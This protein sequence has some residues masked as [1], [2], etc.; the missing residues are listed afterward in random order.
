MTTASVVVTSYRRP[1]ALRDC[2]AGVRAQRRAPDELI[3]VLHAEDDL[4]PPTLDGD[5]LRVVTVAERGS[6]AALNA[7]FAAATGA[8][9]ALIDDDAVPEPDWLE[10]ILA[11]FARDPRIAGV[12]GRDIVHDGG[13]I[14]GRAEQGVLGRFRGA[15]T[16]GRIQWFGR[17]VGNHH[18]GEGAARDVDV[19]KGANMAF[20]RQAVL[21]HGFDER[22]RGRGAQPHSEL[23]IC[24]PL[25][26]RG[27]RLIY[28]PAIL[29]NHYPAPRPAG[30]GRCDFDRKA[31]FDWT[32]N[33]AL[34]ILDHLTSGRRAAFALWGVLVGTKR[35]PG[36]AAVVRHALAGHPDAWASF[37]A[38]Q[39]ARFAAWRTHRSH[40]RLP[41]GPLTMTVVVTTYRRTRTL[42][43]C[44]DGIAAQSRP[45]D[46][47]LVVV[48]DS[49]EESAAF[50]DA[51]SDAR[52]V[53][54]TPTGLVAALNRGLGAATGDIV[55]FVDDD[56]VPNRD[57]LERL[58][59][60]FA[61][62]A[63][64]S[65]VGGRDEVHYGGQVRGRSDEGITVRTFGPPHV[66]RV[67]WFGRQLG[68]HHIG[69]G[70]ARDVDVLKGVNMSFRRLEVAELGFDE[71]LK[72]RGVEVHSELSICL[73]LRRRGLR[74]I[75]DPAILVR[76][77]PQSRGFGDEREDLSREAIHDAAHN[78]ALQLL[79]YLPAAQR[80]V[81]AVWSFAVGTSDAPGLA[82]LARHLITGV[83]QPW[84]R[85]TAT[86]AGRIAARKSRKT[87]RQS[88]TTQN[89]NQPVAALL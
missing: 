1:D 23:S 82:I 53:L 15:P 33:E 44:L 47:V 66:G 24:L 58:E 86:Q 62:D 56:A 68:N 60:H 37:G 52:R 10:R 59:A 17:H 79:D 4:T 20:R 14:L 83:S 42:G 57:W 84:T 3:V 55:A 50:V 70:G 22:L 29:V 54:V 25:R 40:P 12:G 35:A 8:V 30:D 21:G 27:L 2:L 51:R 75:Y 69:V 34:Q 87:D 74:L 19:L 31:T 73:P 28:D 63:R 26:R 89:D 81:F 9:V 77:Y 45:A 46:E 11:T 71:R 88:R 76:H 65:A 7:G 16:V 72:G 5:D 18:V 64:V 43:P 78:E 38:A 49:D 67:Q 32:Y 13:R 39:R 6:V 80:S 36:L 85:F 41:S 61:R 48:H